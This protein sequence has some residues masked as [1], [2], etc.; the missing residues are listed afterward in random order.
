MAHDVGCG[1]AIAAHWIP[2]NGLA[3]NVYHSQGRVVGPIGIVGNNHLQNGFVRPVRESDAR[4]W[5]RNQWEKPVFMAIGTQDPVLGPPVMQALCK[6]IAG[7]TD[8]YEHPEA[9]HF[10]Q[11]WGEEIAQRAL[12]TFGS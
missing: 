12:A 1:F 3:G 9:G 11:E 6:D 2:E 4:D 7:C 10:V 8:P 5:L